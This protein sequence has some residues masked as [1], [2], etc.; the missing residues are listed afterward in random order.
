MVT[1]SLDSN[2]VVLNEGEVYCK[3]CGGFGFE[4]GLYGSKHRFCK[5]CGG[6]GKVDW[7]EELLINFRSK[8]IH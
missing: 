3:S 4:N 5:S 2:Q 6:S 1:I 8:N 7:L